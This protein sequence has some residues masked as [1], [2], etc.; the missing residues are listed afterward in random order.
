[1][2]NGKTT[3]FKRRIYFI[4]KGFQ[5]KFILKFCVLVILGGLFTIGI[6][7]LFAM[8]SATISFVNSR[9]VVKTTADF[10]LPILLQTLA[11]V[12]VI[13]SLA[14]IILALLFSH[15]VAGPLYRL[16]K[17][18]QILGEGNIP[19]EFKIRHFDQLQDLATTFDDMIKKIREKLISLK[20]NFSS[21]KEKL[22]SI[23]EDE[24]Q[25]HRRLALNELKETSKKLDKIIQYF[26]I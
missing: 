12:T 19:A 10:I 9:V 5:A 3:T 1:M 21:L 11:I 17:I 25:E 20:E 26:K 24:V 23:S 4:E 18:M 6:Q 7:Y 2:E 8:H 22:S 15:K 13:V 16:K 14:T